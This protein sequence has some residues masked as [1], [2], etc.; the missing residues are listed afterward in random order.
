MEQ[1]DSKPSEARVEPLRG[2]CQSCVGRLDGLGAKVKML[3]GMKKGG[4]GPVES[5][6]YEVQREMKEVN[7]TVL[8]ACASMPEICPRFCNV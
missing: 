5:Q 4:L 3:R 8:A 2:C 1:S 6:W 7:V